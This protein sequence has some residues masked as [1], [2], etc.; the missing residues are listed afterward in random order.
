M[1][2]LITRYIV[3]SARISVKGE[4]ANRFINLAVKS[5][6]TF[7]NY[8]RKGDEYLLTMKCGDFKRLRQI[9][10]QTM[11]RIKL[12]GK[13]GLP[14][15]LKPVKKHPGL[16]AGLVFGIVFYIFMSGQL[17]LLTV[18]G[19]GRYTK[20]QILSAASEAGVKIGV[21]MDSFD[22]GIAAIEIMRRLPELE[23]VSVNTWGSSAE[24]AVKQTDRK[25]VIEDEKSVQNLVAAKTGLITEII[26]PE[27]MARVKVGEGVKKGDL[28]VSGIW[29]SN[30]RKQEW[31]KTDI[32]DIFTANSRGKVMAQVEERITVTLP[33]KETLY[34]AGESHSRYTL[35]FFG[36]KLPFTPTFVPS[37]EYKMDSKQHNLWLLGKELPLYVGVDELTKQI[38]KENII[39]EEQAKKRLTALMDEKLREILGEDGSVVSSEKPVFKKG[40]KGYTMT[41][42]HICNENIAVPHKVVLK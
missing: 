42:K 33:L 20:E 15:R 31:L 32:V 13:K 3:G 5:G 36:I 39:D 2:N 37:G 22:E 38:K 7:W 19:D 12:I 34:E 1:L 21:P 28:L 6:L 14:F 30:E 23:W 8:R 26:A 27:G 11:V 41:Q 40:E 17:W 25:P 35:G 16:V 10:R 18:S 29:D 9:K 24:I 4:S